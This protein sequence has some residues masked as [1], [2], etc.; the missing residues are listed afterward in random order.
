MYTCLFGYSFWWLQ[1]KLW[2]DDD[3]CVSL[4][5]VCWFWRMSSTKMNK[6]SLT[7]KKKLTTTPSGK[8]CKSRKINYHVTQKTLSQIPLLLLLLSSSIDHQRCIPV[9][10]IATTSSTT[11]PTT[12]IILSKYFYALYLLIPCFMCINKVIRV[13][14][15]MYSLIQ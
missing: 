2:E 11:P 15:N 10:F 5:M 3:F 6:Y 13:S 1:L 8:T 14:Y 9:V 4:K 12:A 7:T